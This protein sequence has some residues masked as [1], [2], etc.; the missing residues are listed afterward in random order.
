MIPKLIWCFWHSSDLPKSIEKSIMSWRL[1]NPDYKIHIIN[2]NNIKDFLPELNLKN[3]SGIEGNYQLLSDIVRIHL[4]YKYG[5]F[6]I[7]SSTFSTMSFD[8]WLHNI[9]C[10]TES[11]E[12]VGY[13]NPLFTKKKF[14]KSSPVLENWFFCCPKKS[15]FIKLWKDE[16]MKLV[17]DED[18]FQNKLESDEVDIQHLDDPVYFRQ[19]MAAQIILQSGYSKKNMI[20]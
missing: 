12:F 9:L 11:T 2:K 15:K 10:I 8:H 5:G 6:W 13:F 4:I 20:I 7:D 14:M 17:R 3:I 16:F 19:H 18:Y 1:Y